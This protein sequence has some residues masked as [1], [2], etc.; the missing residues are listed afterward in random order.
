MTLRRSLLIQIRVI[1]VT[2][3]AAPGKGESVAIWVGIDGVAPGSP[4]IQGGVLLS[5]GTDGTTGCWA[6]TEWVPDLPV[7]ELPSKF[8]CK[9]GDSECP[10]LH[11]PQNHSPLSN[12]D[13]Y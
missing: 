2:L 3:P 11:R 10:I 9:A 12:K 5:T 4:L 1:E 6:W 8:G 13:Q 7:Y